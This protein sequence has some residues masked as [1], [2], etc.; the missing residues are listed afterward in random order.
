MPTTRERTNKYAIGKQAISPSWPIALFI[1]LS[2]A[3]LTIW[4][5]PL[6]ATLALALRDEQYTHILPI[7][8]ISVALLLLDSQNLRRQDLNTSAVKP[9]QSSRSV[10]FASGLLALALV[11]STFGKWRSFSPSFDQQLSIDMFALILWWIASF[12]LCFRAQAFRRALFPLGFLFWMVPFPTIVLNPIV[13]LLQYGSAAAAHLLFL[14]ARIP[15]A[16]RGTLVHIPGLTMEVA[17]ECSSIRSSMILLVI[18][19]VLAHLLLRSSWRKIVVVAIAIPLSVAKNGLRIFVLGVLATRVDPSYLTGR[20]HRQGGIIF[21]LIALAM[22]FLLVW[23][24]SRG[25]FQRPTGAPN[26]T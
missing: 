19:M 2:A 5:A 23:I 20:L 8:P 14:I 1:I 16:Q 7:L 24:L 11:I 25:D 3:S 13:S 4:L 22:I 9:F 21:L 10:K 15:V 6:G 18:S 17:P 12:L 26:Q